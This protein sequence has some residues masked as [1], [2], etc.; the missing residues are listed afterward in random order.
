MHGSWMDETQFVH[1]QHRAV[2][3][4]PHQGSDF[5]FPV[6]VS[7]ADMMIF[8]KFRFKFFEI[9]KICY[10]NLNKYYQNS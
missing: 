4:C 5:L 6:S 2:R 9:L 10:S 3:Q 7:G 1:R 8:S